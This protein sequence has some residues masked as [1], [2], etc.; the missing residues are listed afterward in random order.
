MEQQG[1][2]EPATRVLN[3]SMLQLEINEDHLE[4]LRPARRLMPPMAYIRSV[5]TAF[6]MFGTHALVIP[7]MRFVIRRSPLRIYIGDDWT[8]HS[9]L[10]EA[11]FTVESAGSAAHPFWQL[12]LTIPP[13]GTVNT[14]QF[15]LAYFSSPEEA[16]QTKAAIEGFLTLP[17]KPKIVTPKRT[18]M[19]IMER[20]TAMPGPFD[21]GTYEEICERTE[22]AVAKWAQTAPI[23]WLGVIIA[24]SQSDPDRFLFGVREEMSEI[25]VD[26]QILMLMKIW[27][28]KAPDYYLHKLGEAMLADSGGPREFLI[29]SLGEV[30]DE[31]NLPW[32]KRL[33]EQDTALTDIEI[34]E[35]FTVL[36]ISQQAEAKVL[37]ALLYTRTPPE[38][39]DIR[40]SI[41]AILEHPKPE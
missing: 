28:C 20:V 9:L 38:M 36:E 14:R 1:P 29:R 7:D 34:D 17:K 23:Q 13:D 25:F 3:F 16:E 21:E 5:K 8:G 30:S 33:L 18:V 26:P 35:I 32:L 11:R 27:S 40:K 4:C 6:Q 15:C 2:P 37:L 10:R 41:D 31:K 22:E 12:W 39:T 24:Y 19:D